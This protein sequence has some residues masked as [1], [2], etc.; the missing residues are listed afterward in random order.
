M[1][2]NHAEDTLGRAKTKKARRNRMLLMIVGALLAIN[3]VVGLVLTGIAKTDDPGIAACSDMAERV[4]HPSKN[5][6]KTMTE[7]EWI[8]IRQPFE[9]SSYADI[10]VA[11]T[12]LVDAVYKAD[13]LMA[14]KKDEDADLGESL[15]ILSVIQTNYANLQTACKNH[16]VDLP[17]LGTK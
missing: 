12:N 11:G 17:G 6:N 10:S 3:G 8:R 5:E 7:E 9:K 14:N 15:A 4:G 2:T 13:Q 1:Y 16:G